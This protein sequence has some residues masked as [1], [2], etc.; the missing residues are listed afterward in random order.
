MLKYRDTLAAKGSQLY[1][2]IQS[3]DKKLMERIYKETS[4]N[5]AKLHSKEDREWFLMMTK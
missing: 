4:A 1:L 3:G 2:A 5:Y